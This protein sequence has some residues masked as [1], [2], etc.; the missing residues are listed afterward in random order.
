MVDSRGVGVLR[1]P[2]C[3]GAEID[4]ESEDDGKDQGGITKCP[5][6]Y[7]GAPDF[8]H[9]DAENNRHDHCANAVGKM[10]GD[11]EIPVSG[12]ETIVRSEREF[13]NG[14]ARVGMPHNS[15]DQDL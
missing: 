2:D 15:T 8:T 5:F 7:R 6:R 3:Q 14:E 12:Q 13:G 11:I 10:D 9:K 1:G 4:L